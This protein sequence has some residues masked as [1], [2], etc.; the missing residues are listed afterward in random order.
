MTMSSFIGS[1]VWG[2]IL[3]VGGTALLAVFGLI[4]RL[5]SKV[6]RLGDKLEELGKDIL[7]QRNDRNIIR[8]SDLQRSRL[9]RRRND[10]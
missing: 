6:D 10:F 9:R 7:D 2:A 1:P 8:W 5:S 4:W 3:T